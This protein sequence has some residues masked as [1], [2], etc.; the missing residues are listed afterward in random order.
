VGLNASIPCHSS[1]V[2]SLL[3]CPCLK[4]LRS[5]DVPGIL[6]HL[7]RLADP[8]RERVLTMEEA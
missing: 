4:I 6:R 8:T 1:L 5:T 2:D 3:L 7:F